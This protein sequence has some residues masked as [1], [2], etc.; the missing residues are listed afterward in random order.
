MYTDKGGREAR[1]VFAAMGLPLLAVCA[2]ASF[3]SEP[4]G[5][6]VARAGVEIPGGPRTTQS[7][8]EGEVGSSAS[9]Q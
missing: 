1:W 4:R 3:Q 6:S 5:P 2:K 7:Q 9:A 8:G